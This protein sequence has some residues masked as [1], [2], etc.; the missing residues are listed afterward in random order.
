[1]NKLLRYSLSILLALLVANVYADNVELTTN[2]KTVAWTTGDEEC[3]GTIGDFTL[4]LSKNGSTA[5]FSGVTA[6][7]SYFQIKKGNKL[8]IAHK[9]GLTITKVV[10]NCTGSAQKMTIDGKTVEP[11]E[12]TLTWEGSTA[13]FE[14]VNEGTPMKVASIDITYA[15]GSTSTV[16]APAIEG[17]SAFAGT[18]TVKISGAEGTVVYYTLDGNA[19]TT[20]S[21]T[22]GTA[23]VDV[24]LSATTTVKAIAVSGGTASAVTTAEFKMY[25]VKTI[26]DLVALKSS[27]S[28]VALKLDGAKLIYDP[29]AGTAYAGYQTFVRQDGS[30]VMFYAT[31]YGQGIAENSLLSGTIF[32]DCVYDNGITAIMSTA[33]T[34]L[35]ALTITASEE[36]A[37]PTPATLAELLKLEHAADLVKV[38]NV[39]I[40]S[41][42][43]AYYGT[44]YYLNDDE[45]NKVEC[46]TIK[47]ADLKAKADDGNKYTVKAMFGNCDEN[48]LPQLIVL[49]EIKD[50]EE[51]NTKTIAELCAMTEDLSDVVL[52]L[53]GAKVIYDPFNSMEDYRGFYCYVNEGGKSIMFYA[54][55]YGAKIAQNS[56]L[57]GTVHVTY[58]CA[59]GIPTVGANDLT[60]LDNITVTPSDEE[61]TPT[62]ATL[63]EV[64]NLEH[65]ADIVKLSGVYVTTVNTSDYGEIAAL[66]DGADIT[67]E[68]PSGIDKSLAG[69][70]KKYDVVALFGD[71]S[72][73]GKPRLT[74]ISATESDATGIK[75]ISTE[76]S[77]D[78]AP[79]FNIAGQKV[80]KSFKGIVVK[81]GKKYL[82]K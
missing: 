58:S 22:N 3:V 18:T 71:C 5:S 77:D 10:L 13:A 30:A 79:A 36:E 63:E 16:E 17:A 12:G 48:G 57:S 45:G 80:D 29:Y 68:A 56:L 55:T 52:K 40:T 44:T 67:I 73:A 50:A 31:L 21:T 14:A 4:T 20:E 28:G 24:E 38:S 35:S 43:S 65:K 72:S 66:T 46:A 33:D 26:A 51:E 53:D 61:Y 78:N 41:G 75:G 42:A 25:E 8:A 47:D 49:S 15:G 23:T 11:S 81:N 62:V 2:S 9:D 69:N 27:Y 70:G 54:V 7:A 1:M 39:T 74:V 6:S 59:S 34:D 60:N 76:E 19:P 64:G 32:V 37:E 82:M